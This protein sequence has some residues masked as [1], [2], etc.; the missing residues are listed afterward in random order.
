MRSS[1]GEGTL[2]QLLI[3]TNAFEP[4]LQRAA[5]NTSG[6]AE[7]FAKLF[8]EIWRDLDWAALS[9][10]VNDHVELSLHAAVNPQELNP[11][12]SHW[13]ALIGEAT[14]FWNQVP[15][16][17]V[18]AAATK[19]DAPLASKQ[20]TRLASVVPEL[21]TILDAIDELSVGFNVARDLLPALGPEFGSIIRLGE[22]GSPEI[23]LELELKGGEAV[24]ATGL[25][26]AQTLE[27]IVLRPIFVLYSLEHNHEFQDTSRIETSEIGEMRVHSLTH[28]TILPSW[29]TPSFAVTGDKI[30]FASSPSLLMKKDKEPLPAWIDSAIAKQFRS[31]VGGDEIPKAFINVSRLRDFLVR[32]QGAIAG[33][34]AEKTAVSSSNASGNINDLTSLLELIDFAV[35]ST[36]TQGSV[37]RWTLS[38]FTPTG[39]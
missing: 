35:L 29:L 12:E 20:I 33:K 27:L 13:L 37:R 22:S 19:L 39:N 3:D 21:S 31:K 6:P 2:A 4:L 26:L 8:R 5:E 14:Q 10:R 30:R 23:M 7:F 11:E 17:V 32:N 28:S 16:D 9:L 38:A 1:I 36:S 25:T 34:I 18:A 15:A 24:G